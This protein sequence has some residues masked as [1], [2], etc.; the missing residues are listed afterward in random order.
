MADVGSGVES[1]SATYPLPSTQAHIAAIMKLS[2]QIW[3]LGRVLRFFLARGLLACLGTEG[4]L[5]T[6]LPA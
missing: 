4:I 3:L 5:A 6:R 1:T 2:Q